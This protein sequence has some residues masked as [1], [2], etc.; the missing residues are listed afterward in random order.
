V[1]FQTEYAERTG[2]GVR[3]STYSTTLSAGSVRSTGRY[4]VSRSTGSRP[5]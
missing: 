4:K 5:A 1:G 2:A 3:Y